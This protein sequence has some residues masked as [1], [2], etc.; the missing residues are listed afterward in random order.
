M[1]AGRNV[2]SAPGASFMSGPPLVTFLSEMH[3]RAAD[4]VYFQPRMDDKQCVLVLIGTDEWGRKEILGLTDGYRE[5]T[6]SWRELLLD[7][8]R[9]GLTH[10]PDLAVGDGALASG[11]PCVR[12]LGTPVNSAVGSTKPAMC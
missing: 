7:L 11:P 9:R 6:Q 5:S 8:K 2:T 12:C 10:A 1:S 3:C 4:G